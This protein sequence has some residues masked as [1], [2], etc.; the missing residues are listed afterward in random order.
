MST[1]IVAMG[2]GGF[3]T[4]EGFA[5][6][7]LDRYVLSLTEA[8]NPLVCFVPTAS[9]DNGLYVSRFM[10]A[11]SRSRARTS[12]LTLWEGAAASLAR[13]DEVDVFL[14]GGGNTVNMMA[15]WAA[16]GVS[17][18]VMDIAHDPS[19]NVV[20]AGV[21]A[22]GAAW[23]EACA[24][25]GYGTGVSPFPHGLGLLPGSFCPHFDGEADRRPQ[26]KEY[27]DT[28]QLPSGY[29]A[30]NGAALH[31]VDGQLAGCY[32]ERDGA[33]VYRV[34]QHENGASITAQ[35]MTVL[36]T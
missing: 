9:G 29:G 3:S 24:T 11:Y 18:K 34:D 19:R 17:R 32:A 13:L 10:N 6:T 22:G 27:V 36:T 26:F 31:F 30:D 23:F 35:P 33:T 28:G 1:H 14:V 4:S 25:D 16:H 5:A 12:V 2:G 7:S 21:G 15:L 20:L 8:P